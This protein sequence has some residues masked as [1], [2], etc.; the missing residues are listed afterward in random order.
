MFVEGFHKSIDAHFVF[1]VRRWVLPQ[2]RHQDCGSQQFLHPQSQ[3]PAAV[4]LHCTRPRITPVELVVLWFRCF[5]Y[6]CFHSWRFVCP[7][8]EKLFPSA[9]TNS[10][11]VMGCKDGSVRFLDHTLRIIAWTD[12]VTHLTAP[13]QR[14]DLYVSFLSLSCNAVPWCQCPF[15][16]TPPWCGRLLL[17]RCAGPRCQ[18]VETT[19]TCRTLW[20][21]L[22]PPRC[23]A[24]ACASSRRSSRC[25][26]RATA[27]RRARTAAP[28]SFLPRTPPARCWPAWA[29]PAW[30]SS[31]TQTHAWYGCAMEAWQSLGCCSFIVLLMD[32]GSCR[33]CPCCLCWWTITSFGP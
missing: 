13:C 20:S 32:C 15:P 16:P 28:A 7:I 10:A 4:F 2:G 3:L 8:I 30:C 18:R 9:H 25:C 21:A 19:L 17:L 1:V 26:C 29:R 6:W 33:W 24:Y 11:Q 22:P 27:G 12:S 23:C 14:P 5:L 31:L